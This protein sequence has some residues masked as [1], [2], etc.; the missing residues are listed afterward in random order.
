[1]KIYLAG[2]FRCKNELKPYAD[3]IRK[4][5]H[6]IVSTW[7]ESGEDWTQEDND[8]EFYANKDL[9]EIKECEVFVLYNPPNEEVVTR[10]AFALQ[11]YDKTPLKVLRNSGVTG[12]KDV[13]FGYALALGKRVIGISE[14]GPVNVFQ[15][16]SKVKMYYSLEELLK[17]LQEEVS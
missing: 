1:M 10:L 8:G 3:K 15:K 9:Q 16:F 2:P 12:G 13:E 14:S 4:L 6:E 5:G 17:E 11:V 7:L